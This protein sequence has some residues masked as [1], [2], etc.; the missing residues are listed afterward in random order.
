MSKINQFPFLHP[1]PHND[2]EPAPSYS[3]A[4]LPSDYHLSGILKDHIVKR[5]DDDDDDDDDNNNNNNNI[6]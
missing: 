3:W 4:L 5:D 1:T 2:S 6:Y